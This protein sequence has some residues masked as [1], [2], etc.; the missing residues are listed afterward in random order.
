[1]NPDKKFLKQAVKQASIS[2]QKGGFP[3][4]AVLIKDDK[5]IAKG[6][7]LRDILHDPTEHSE[8][9]CI[10]KACKKLKTANLSGS[11]LYA[12]LEP[13]LMCFSVANQAGVS[14]IF[15]GCRKNQH[16]VDINCYEGMNN[17]ADINKLN[18]RKIDLKYIGDF[19]AESLKL[20]SDWEKSL[21]K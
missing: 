17:S 19:E 18:N 6:V 11:I 10:R 3:A 12:S 2:L 7:S 20:L 8:T 1:M 9:S 15:F 4:G 5:V 13:C 14:K 21:E 16:M